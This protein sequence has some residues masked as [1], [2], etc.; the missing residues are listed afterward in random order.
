MGLGKTVQLLALVQH[1]RAHDARKLSGPVLLVCPMSVIG[2]WKREAARF[3]PDLRVLTHHGI[4]RGADAA[5][6]KS[7]RGNDVVLTTY[8]LAHRDREALGRVNWRAIVLDEAQNIKNSG[9]KQTRAIKSLQAR[10]RVAL[11]GTPVENGLSELWSIM[12]F[13]NPGQLGAQE[14]FQRRFAA[15]IESGNVERAAD[16]RRVVQPFLLRRVKSDK[17]IIA[18]LPDKIEHTVQCTLTREQ[19]TLYQAV[20]K[21]MLE[22][23][24]DAERF[25]R[26]RLIVMALTRLKQ[27][28]NHPAHYL[29]DGSRLTGRSG[30]LARLEG[31]LEEALSAGDKALVFSQ[32]TEMAGPLA[33]YLQTR[34]EREVA[35]LHGGVG[36][37]KR[38]ELVWR[39]QEAPNGPQIFVLSLKAGGLGLN[40]T[41]ANHV[42]HYDRW[43][44]PAV[45][46]QATD[47]AYRIGQTRNVQ[48]HKLIC[49]GTLE[50]RIDQ[51][52]RKKRA[53]ADQI[54]G[55]GESWLTA[56]S[57]DQ[58]RSLFTLGGDAVAE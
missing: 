35:Y 2:N 21:R 29:H 31:M 14:T 43:W 5:F 54:V 19:A 8:T 44:N 6:A 58:L 26:G 7:A 49:L 9:N 11:T 18:D 53:L 27:I 13:L 51:L 41:A 40:L 46:N 48:V 33:R 57:T 22:Q 38:D 47:R 24:A 16:L 36:Q 3:T 45:E 42:F 50:E 52:L 25:E 17:S 4:G 30:K 12:D 37:R 10:Q 55:D 1:W 39:F 23:I 15:P 28:C 34:F 56:L 20:T 32:Y